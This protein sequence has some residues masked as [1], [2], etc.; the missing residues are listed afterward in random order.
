MGNNMDG[1]FDEYAKRYLLKNLG[2]EREKVVTKICAG[3]V[4]DIESYRYLVGALKALDT[5]IDVVKDAF[6]VVN[7]GDSEEVS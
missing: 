5:A 2:D 1:V 6:I 4:T 7:N 3:N